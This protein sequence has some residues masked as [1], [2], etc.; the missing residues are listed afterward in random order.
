M[1]MMAWSVLIYLR[2][3]LQL[4]ADALEVEEIVWQ[5]L[6]STMAAGKYKFCEE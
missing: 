5:V 3:L 1:K 2:V 4:R 6:N